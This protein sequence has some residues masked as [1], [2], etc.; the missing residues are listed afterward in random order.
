MARPCKSIEGQSRH[1]SKEEIEKRKE[2]ESRLKGLADK[3][4]FPPDY[5]T[6]D[7]KKIYIDIF[8]ELEASQILSNLDVYILT[9]CS[10]AIDRLQ[11]IEKII[12]K[13]PK[14]I[15]NKELMS[16]KD[17][18]NKEFY[19]CCNELSLSPQSRAKFGSLSLKAKD[20]SED[21]VLKALLDNEDEE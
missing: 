5:L 3:I 11:Y 10:I 8:K 14:A 6:E 13:N 16:A 19:R 21:E 7:Q 20:E 12:S 15:M 18:Y 17:K 1:N 2:T 9:S 4:E